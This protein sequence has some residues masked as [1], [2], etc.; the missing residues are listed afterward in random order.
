MQMTNNAARTVETTHRAAREP[1]GKVVEAL[2]AELSQCLG[3]L[4]LLRRARCPERIA[5]KPRPRVLKS[6]QK[7][8][9]HCV[10]VDVGREVLG[11]ALRIWA[12]SP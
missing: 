3:L 10:R 4:R 2:L 5:H 9:D 11:D 8:P 7:A 6:V 1:I 12:A